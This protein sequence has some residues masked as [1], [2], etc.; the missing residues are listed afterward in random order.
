MKSDT[1][2]IVTGMIVP[3]VLCLILGFIDCRNWLVAIILIII[4]V[5]LLGCVYG[6]GYV[7]NHADVRISGIAYI[8]AH[9]DY[10]K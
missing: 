3:A 2:V 9:T 4:S 1:L 8:T 10:S 5:S 6:S 7:V